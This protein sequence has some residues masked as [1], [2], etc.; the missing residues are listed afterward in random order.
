MDRK[1][2]HK[3]RQRKN[4]KKARKFE[5]LY[6]FYFYNQYDAAK[7]LGVSRSVISH[8]CT[9]NTEVPDDIFDRMIRIFPSC[10]NILTC[11]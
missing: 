4:H 7:V 10:K 9:G 5:A 1:Q 3:A 2:Q 8:Y 6:R 11:L